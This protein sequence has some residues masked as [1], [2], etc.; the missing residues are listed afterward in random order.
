M[1]TAYHK[2]LSQKAWSRFTLAVQLANIGS[3]V[4]RAINW[5]KRGNAE[6]ARLAFY[7]ALELT[8]LTIMTRPG[9]ARIREFTRMRTALVDYFDGTNSFASSDKNWTAYF[10]AFTVAAAH[11][12]ERGLA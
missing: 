2:D 4:I 7:R 11:E 8:D 6:Y 5:Q 3:E 12:R 10:T 1:K 9:P